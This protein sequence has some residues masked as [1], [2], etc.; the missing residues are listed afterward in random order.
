MK[1]PYIPATWYVENKLKKD[2]DFLLKLS[3]PEV[4]EKTKEHEGHG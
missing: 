2:F 4:I 3:R 1:I